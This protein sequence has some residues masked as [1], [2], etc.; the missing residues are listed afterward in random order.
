[1][2]VTADIGQCTWQLIKVIGSRTGTRILDG[3][4]PQNA[5]VDIVKSSHVNICDHGR[6]LVNYCSIPA[7]IILV[8]EINFNLSK[9]IEHFLIFGFIYIDSWW[10]TLVII[11]L[12][13]LLDLFHAQQ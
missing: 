3:I 6:M 13:Y 8:Y 1:M 4:D 12:I 11:L 7:I 5:Y 2:H 9:E 10:V